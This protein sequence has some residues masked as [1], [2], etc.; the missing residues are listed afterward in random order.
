MARLQTTVMHGRRS[1]DLSRR[2]EPLRIAIGRRRARTRAG[3][4][5]FVTQVRL[6]DGEA[7]VVPWKAARGRPAPGQ[8]AP[9]RY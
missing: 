4:E 8:P 7:I 2:R 6:G 5:K 3:E 9:A 1:L